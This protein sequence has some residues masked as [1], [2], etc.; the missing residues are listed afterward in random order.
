MKLLGGITVL[1]FS[2][3][4]LVHYMQS[5]SLPRALFFYHLHDQNGLSHLLSIVLPL[6]RKYD[7]EL[8]IYFCPY[9]QCHDYAKKLGL[10]KTDI[11]RAVLDDPT[12][13][14]NFLCFL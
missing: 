9:T 11:P 12:N 2:N 8:Q 5:I 1:D 3:H 13:G 6:T 14:K 10:T 4:A 7:E